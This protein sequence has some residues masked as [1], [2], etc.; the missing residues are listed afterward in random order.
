MLHTTGKVSTYS[1]QKKQ[2]KAELKELCSLGKSRFEKQQLTH[3]T[4]HRRRFSLC[5]TC[6]HTRCWKIAPRRV[7]AKFKEKAVA[8][9]T[10]G[11]DVHQM[12]KRLQSACA[13]DNYF[14]CTLRPTFSGQFSDPS[15]NF[16]HTWREMMNS[17]RVL[18]YIK[19]SLGKECARCKSV[20]FSFLNYSL[21]D[22]AKGLQPGSA[23]RTKS[24][25]VN[26]AAKDKHLRRQPHQHTGNFVVIP[27]V[28]R[29]RALQKIFLSTFFRHY[30]A[31]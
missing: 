13:L 18:M 8:R 4:P 9:A 5:C 30:T 12:T 11:V 25:D 24:C 14:N 21:S 17:G 29:K 31:A 7:E 23:L 27:I 26:M 16:I 3:L 15:G 19:K 22:A 28:Y 10:R 1:T 2:V 6:E 20:Y